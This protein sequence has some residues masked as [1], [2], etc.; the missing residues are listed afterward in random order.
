MQCQVA[1]MLGGTNVW[2]KYGLMFRS[3]PTQE[4]PDV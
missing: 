1:A 3:K 4:S 2:A